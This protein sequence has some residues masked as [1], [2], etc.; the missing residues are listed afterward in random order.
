MAL[1]ATR[2]QVLGLVLGQG[3]RLAVAGVA[4]GVVVALALSRV[5]ASLLYGVSA[6]DLVT[7]AGVPVALTLVAMLA[8]LVPARRATRVDPVVAMRTE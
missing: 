5:V 7:F 8:T 2:G 6:T 1:G 3:V 4:I